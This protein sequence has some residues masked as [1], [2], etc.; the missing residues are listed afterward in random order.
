MSRAV[1]ATI[2]LSALKH[3]WDAACA[4]APRS[5][6]LAVVKADAYGHGAARVAGAL[7]GAQAF[8]VAGIDEAVALREAGIRA[9][10]CLLSGFQESAELPVMAR[11]AIGSVVHEETQIEDLQAARL[12]RPI[13]V[14]LKIDSGM[15]RLGFAPAQV[16]AAVARLVAVPAVGELR[17][18]SHFANADDT[19]DDY[20][21]AQLK[22]FLDIA[23]KYKYACSIANSAG[24]V[25]WP[26]THLD[27]V[28]PGIMLYGASPLLGRAAVD[29]GLQPVMS[30]TSRIIAVR[31]LQAGDPIGYGGDWVCPAATRVAII[32]C[33]YGDGYPRHAPSGTPVWIAGRAAPLV[34][35][36]SMDLL[37]VD[38][39]A[40]PEA[41]V[42]TPV[43]LWGAHLPVDTVAHHAGTIAYE[44]LC[45][46]TARVPRDTLA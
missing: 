22:C 37:A 17:L 6:V 41:Q 20:T 46:V 38:L 40:H 10:I 13:A 30:L 14:W 9:P 28:R 18:M 5:R 23:V 32:A 21:A 27:W 42:G 31:T 7:S 24:V 26:D 19:A 35:R 12:D 15:H 36:V 29:L 43:E 44:L 45:G 16:E 8:G 2:N 11:H 1:R 33:G 4:H 34:G 39:A 25:A 3:N